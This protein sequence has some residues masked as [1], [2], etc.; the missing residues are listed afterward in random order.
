MIWHAGGEYKTNV[1]KTE[2]AG[3]IT[4]GLTAEYGSIVAYDKD[5]G[6][7]MALCGELQMD[8]SA[9]TQ[10]SGTQKVQ[11]S[12]DGNA[13]VLLDFIDITSHGN[14]KQLRPFGNGYSNGYPLPNR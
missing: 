3:V 2:T 8:G 9:A 11:T 14:C 12:A 6:N 4:L 7:E 5:T 13:D 10:D 1:E